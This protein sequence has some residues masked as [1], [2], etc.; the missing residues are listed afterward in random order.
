LPA[1]ANGTARSCTAACGRVEDYVAALPA[2]LDERS[3]L[4]LV[5]HEYLLRV[6]Q[7]DSP[8]ADEYV[9]RFP[10]LEPPPRRQFCSMPP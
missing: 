7:G 4:D 8:T 3:L 9:R 6:G 1:V 5:Y 2:P 10:H